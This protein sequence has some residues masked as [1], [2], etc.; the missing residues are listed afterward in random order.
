MSATLTSLR[1][2]NLALVEELAWEPDHGFVAITGETGAGKSIILGALTLVLG[3]RAGKDLI[4][5]GA[6]TCSVEAVFEP[7]ND[8]RIISLLA[9]HG[10]DPCEEQRL[11]LKRTLVAAGTGRQFVNGSSCTLAL[12]RTLGD[13]L[14]DLHGPHDHQSLFSREQQTRLLDRFARAEKIHLQFEDARRKWLGLQEERESILLNAQNAAREADLLTYQTREIEGATLQRGEEETLLA[15]QR[16]ANNARRIRELCANLEA[17]I[18]ENDDSLTAR[19]EEFSRIARELLRLDPSSEAIDFGC[20]ELFLAANEFARSVQS[21]SAR[22]DGDS[23]DLATVEARLDTIQFLKRKYGSTLE[24]VLAFGKQAAGRLAELLSRSE[25]QE[26]LEAEIAAAEKELRALGRN[27]SA[28]RA[29]ASETLAERV[30]RGLKSLGFGKAD[31]G[32][33]LESQK[34][35][36]ANGYEVTEFQFSGNPGQPLRPLR[37]IASSGE[38]SRVML[39]LKSVLADEDDVPILVFDEVDANIGG[40]IASKV[41]AQMRE[42]GKSH[43]VLCITHLPQVAAA[44][45]SQFIVTKS[46]KSNRTLIRIVKA[47]GQPR[48]EEIARM[49][50]GKSASALAHA[51]ALLNNA[52]GN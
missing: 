2:R 21:Y 11:F 5:A 47:Q 16:V 19:V 29:S 41:G 26:S 38:I 15:R 14:I 8:Q 18:S 49:L 9:D 31:F 46:V 36:G 13:L 44:A 35:P 48:L 30:R 50:G 52:G 4:R 40:E 10:I 39:A 23:A 51:G 25:R 45:R 24:E 1:I 43:Q 7:I 37:A 27:L 28:R 22:L 33:A 34:S 3:E 20:K 42:L 32:V 12:L 17:R 6:E